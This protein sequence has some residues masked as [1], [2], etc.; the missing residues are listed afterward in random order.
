MVTFHGSKEA[1]LEEIFYDRLIRNSF[2]K[3]SPECGFVL[4]ETVNHLLENT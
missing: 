4:D 2:S 1:L 3:K